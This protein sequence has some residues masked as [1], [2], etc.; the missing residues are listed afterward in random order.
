MTLPKAPRLINADLITAEEI[1]AKL[2]ERCDD[3]EAGKVQDAAAAFAKVS[4]SYR[5][6]K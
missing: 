6:N 1:Y 5:L 2:Q 4:E 3:M